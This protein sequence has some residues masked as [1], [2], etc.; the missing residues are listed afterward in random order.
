MNNGKMY[1]GGLFSRAILIYDIIKFMVIL[2]ACK[3]ICVTCIHNSLSL[4]HI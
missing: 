1:P 2:Y 4:K 3:N